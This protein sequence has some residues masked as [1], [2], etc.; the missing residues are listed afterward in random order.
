M[1]NELIRGQIKFGV[2][3]FITRCLLALGY[4]VQF[5]I[6]NAG[7]YGAPQSRRRIIFWG[8]KNGELMP[9][10]PLPTHSLQ[11]PLQKSLLPT[12]SWSLPVTWDHQ[13]LWLLQD[14]VYEEVTGLHSCAPLD[15]V[16]IEDAIGDLPP[17]DWEHPNPTEDDIEE[18]E[19]R[20]DIGILT[21]PAVRTET[22]Q[23]VCGFE[24]PAHYAYPPMTSYQQAMRSKGAPQVTYHYTTFHKPTTVEKVLQNLSTSRDGSPSSSTP[25][26]VR[27][28]ANSLFK[29]IMTSMPL[30][31][32]HAGSS[33]HPTQKRGLSIREVARAQGFPDHYK[34]ES[35]DRDPNKLAVNQLRQIGNAVPIPLSHALGRSL[36]E[37][38]VRRW[39]ESLKY[40]P[41][42]PEL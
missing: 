32:R 34:L 42:S 4:Q 22:C 25:R 27:L 8:A 3:K 16:T 37:T 30:N 24:G 20:Q 39:Q 31:G 2:V 29:T 11:N 40:R 7:Q 9:A 14:S 35:F 23:R 12:G 6:L 26:K 33:I 10:F 19:A 15:M 38:L 36:G 5:K 17:F 1:N 21:F 41:P 18:S 28:R 13:G